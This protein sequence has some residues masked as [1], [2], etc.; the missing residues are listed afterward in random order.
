MAVTIRRATQADAHIIAATRLKVWE[1]TYRGIYPDEKL[2]HYDAS[3]YTRRDFNRMGI[4][5]YNYYLFVDEGKCVGYFSFG[6][7]N[8][9]TYKDFYL[10]INDLYLLKPYQRRGLGREALEIIRNY[11]RT[12]G[13]KKF[14]C[15]C[16]AHNHNARAFYAHMGGVEGDTPVFHEDPSDDIV[17]FEFYLGENI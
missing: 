17:H 6:P 5:G 11:C 8:Y 14:F 13:I 2:D 12:R 4:P 15:G 7:Y 3:T 10:T 16:N 9:G 1:E